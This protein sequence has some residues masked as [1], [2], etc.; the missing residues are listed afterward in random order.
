MPRKCWPLR[1]A[2]SAWSLEHRRHVGGATGAF[3]ISMK[4]VSQLWPAMRASKLRRSRAPARSPS[5][6]RARSLCSI[7]ANSAAMRAAEAASSIR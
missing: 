7:A 1:R 6:R 4:A 2:Y 3:A 5:G